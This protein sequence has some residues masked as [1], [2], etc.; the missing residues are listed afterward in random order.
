LKNNFSIYDQTKFSTFAVNSIKSKKNRIAID[1]E[2]HIMLSHAEAEIIEHLEKAIDDIKII[3][4]SSVL[5][6]TACETC[7]LIKTH[8]VIS[9]RFDQ[10]EST[11]YLLERVDFDLILMHRAYNDD[12]WVS[13]FIC[14]FSH[15]N[16]V[17]THSK[18]NNALSVIKEFVKLTLTR[19]EQIFRFIRIDDEQILSIEYDNFMKIR[20]ISTKRIASYTSAQNE[21]I[22]R[23]ERILIMKSRALRIQTI[24]SCELWLEFYKTTNY[25]NNRISKKS[26]DWLIS[27]EILIDERS[28]LF[29]IQSYECRVYSLR[30]I[31][32]RKTKMKSRAM[33]NHLV[34]YDSINVFR[35]W[36]SSKM[37]IIRTRDVLFDFYA[38]YDSCV[39]DLEHF[40]SIKVK[41]VIQILKMLETTFD[42]VLIEQN[43]DD[44]KNLIFETS[45]KKIDELMTDLID[46]QISL[47]NSVFDE[48]SQMIIL[49][50]T[51]NR[52][53]H[54]S[55]TFATSKF[56]HIATLSKVIDQIEIAIQKIQQK[57]QISSKASQHFSISDVHIRFESMSRQV[58]IDSSNSRSLRFDSFN[59]NSKST[60]ARSLSDFVAMNTRSRIRK[61]AYATTLITVDQLDSYFAT[62]SVDLQRSNII[63]VVFK[64]HRDD[65]SIESRYWRQ[66]LHHRFSQEFQS[67][68]IKKLTELKKRETF[69]LIEKRS[70]QIR[71]SL[72]W[73]FKYKFDTNEYVEKFKTWLCFR[74]DL[75]MIYQNIYATTLA[76]RTFRALM[77]IAT[78]FDLDIWQYDAMSAFINNSIDEKIYNECLDDFVK[79]DYCWKLLKTLYDLKQTSILWYRNLINALEDLRLMSMFEINCLY[80]N[81]WLILFFYV[82]DIVILFMKSNANRMR[83]FEKALMQRFE[84]RILSS[85]QWFLSIRITR[86]REKRKIWLCQNSYIIKMTSKFNLKEI[87]CFKTSLIDL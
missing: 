29:H 39:L 51:S 5:T 12:Q 69:L 73:M 22:E 83:I 26:L 27:I 32:A 70:N 62:F 66:M 75:Q 38:F 4:D 68:A 87:K 85:L 53:I 45:F 7:A 49:E 54:S 81:D 30:H 84:M 11:S 1:A 47:K 52:E 58:K 61:H 43:D 21:K 13:H 10:F 79:L 41:N 48:I 37:R 23:F 64:L 71:I 74:D 35:V 55:T 33:I 76:A 15:R 25:L 20:K 42:D 60:K 57:I 9:R 77:I 80:A 56:D 72:I 18:K 31:I 14:F 46:L 40:L 34:R 65:L 63:S 3:D 86:D 8:H 24:L 78:A 19:Y 82:N 2:W 44:S 17:W 28:K 59:S 36:V 6:T 50:M 67:A 16:F